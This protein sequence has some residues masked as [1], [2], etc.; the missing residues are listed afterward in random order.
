MFLTTVLVDQAAALH[1]AQRSQEAIA[2]FDGPGRFVTNM[3][4]RRNNLRIG[5]GLGTMPL[6]K[7]NNWSANFPSKPPPRVGHKKPTSIVPRP[8]N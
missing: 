3:T 6:N 8:T 2:S 5:P 7:A 1:G 4:T